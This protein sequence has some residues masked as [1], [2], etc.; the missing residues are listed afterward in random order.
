MQRRTINIVAALALVTMI[1][2]DLWHEYQS[3]H[4]IAGVLFSACFYGM[5]WGYCYYCYRKY[6]DE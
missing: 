1:A 3:R 5:F 4:S 2:R 6:N